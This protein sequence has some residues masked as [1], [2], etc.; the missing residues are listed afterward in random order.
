MDFVTPAIRWPM[1]YRTKQKYFETFDS[2]YLK[3][4]FIQHCNL[5]GDGRMEKIA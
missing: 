4:N 5:T 1:E 2:S 3:N